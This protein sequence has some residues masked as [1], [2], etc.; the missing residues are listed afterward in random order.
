MKYKIVNISFKFQNIYSFILHLN[1]FSV[2]YLNVYCVSNDITYENE[3]IKA[4]FA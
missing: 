3:Y 1:G 4:D 2:I